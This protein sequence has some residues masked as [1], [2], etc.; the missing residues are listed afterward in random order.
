MRADHCSTNMVNFGAHALCSSSN[1]M[2]FS[3]RL[4]HT[5]QPG[6]SHPTVRWSSVDCLRIKTVDL[7]VRLWILVRQIQNDCSGIVHSGQTVEC[8]RRRVYQELAEVHPWVLRKW[9]SISLIR[10]SMINEL[11]YLINQTVN[12]SDF[13]STDWWRVRAFQILIVRQ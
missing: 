13:G 4:W 8:Q 3:D 10:N 5:S 2:F 7:Q 12:Q 11:I 6:R 9:L 1:L